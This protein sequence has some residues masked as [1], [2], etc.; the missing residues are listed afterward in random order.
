MALLVFPTHKFPFQSKDF[1]IEQ[2]LLS[3]GR[4]L[5]DEEDQIAT[6]GGGRWFVDLGDAALYS[7]DRVMLWRAF[8]SATRYGADPFV[9]PACD[10]RH[11][12]TQGRTLVPHSDGTSFSDSSLY[13]S[14]DCEAVVLED[15]ILRATTLRI[16]ATTGK[17]LIGG[18]RFTIVHPV[19]RDRC[20]QIGMITD[21]SGDEAT[22]QFHTPLREAVTAGTEI[23]FA[24]PRCVVRLDGRM[25][26]PLAG[27]RWA[28]ASVRF[29]E[30]FPG[31]E[32]YS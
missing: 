16:Q 8:K 13:S 9:F 11:Q 2:A 14:S 7:R 21:V 28:S 5:N 20:Y 25:S 15:A 26:A 31:I 30:H 32:G 18:E 22:V 29:V 27:P 17:P 6:D 4:A 19:H 1:D 12:P 10:I 24:N 3:G 23:D